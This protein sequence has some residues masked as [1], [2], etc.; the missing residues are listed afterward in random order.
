MTTSTF[1]QLQNSL[2]AWKRA[3]IYSLIFFNDILLCTWPCTERF[4]LKQAVGR[5]VP[6]YVGAITVSTID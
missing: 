4:D 3:F 5:F 1:T 2:V 6:T